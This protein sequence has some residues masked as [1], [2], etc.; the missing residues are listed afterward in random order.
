MIGSFPARHRLFNLG[1]GLY[2][3]CARR[4]KSDRI[5]A[6]LFNVISKIFRIET[7]TIDPF[8]NYP[9]LFMTSEVL[10]CL[11]Y[12]L[13]QSYGKGHALE[14]QSQYINTIDIQ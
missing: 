1:Y 9:D 5:D 6:G 11:S 2:R 13:D 7:S 4:R 8:A 14:A 3:Q 12:M 10:D